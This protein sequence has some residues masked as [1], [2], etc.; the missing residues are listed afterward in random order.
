LK[1]WEAR[2]GK[3][4]WVR[5]ERPLTNREGLCDGHLLS[6]SFSPTRPI[7]ATCSIQLG[8]G[9]Q[10]GTVIEDLEL[11]DVGSGQRLAG[12][13]GAPDE[14]LAR[15]VSFAADGRLFA[16]ANSEADNFWTVRVWR[17]P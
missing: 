10:R 14:K 7:L 15:Q 17:L 3:L 13:T 5:K 1:L 4:K 11:W 9:R 2:T 12:L 8:T 6:A 16:V